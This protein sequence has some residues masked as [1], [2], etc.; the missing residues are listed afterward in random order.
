MVTEDTAAADKKRLAELIGSLAK[1]QGITPTCVPGVRLMM[2]NCSCRRAKTVYEPSIVIVAQGRKRGYVGEDVYTYDPDNY[3]VLSV[4]LPFECETEAGPDGP[5]LGLS[6]SVDH[7]MLGELLM[8][9]DEGAPPAEMPRGLYATRLTQELRGAAIRLVESMRSPLDGRM[10]GRQIV[11][12]IVYRVL[13]GEQGGALRAVAARHSGFGQI[14]RVLKRIHSEYDQ[15]LDIETLA[16]EAGMSV[17][18]FHQSFKAV[19]CTSPIQY[20]KSIRLHK[21]RLMMLQDGYNAST[22]AGRVG[23][24]SPSQFSR[25]FKRFF[26]HSPAE[27]AARLRGAEA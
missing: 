2:A 22:A 11:R 23:Y 18:S 5:L 12:E 15:A 7:I 1:A 8:E 26:G 24:Q 3:L 20:L 17:S 10:L 9:M 21:A 13:C 25:E 19:T 4:P 14:A 6:V 27:E 16:R